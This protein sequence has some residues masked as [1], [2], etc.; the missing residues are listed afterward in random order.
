M[1]GDAGQR[2]RFSEKSCR[3]RRV[4]TTGC[5]F[6]REEGPP[7]AIGGCL[8]GQGRQ[9]SGVDDEVELKR[10]FVR[11]DVVCLSNVGP[12]ELGRQLADLVQGSHARLGSP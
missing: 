4:S 10:K 3:T 2:V 8:E 11:V 6:S 9:L 1:R 12:E 5:S 7:L